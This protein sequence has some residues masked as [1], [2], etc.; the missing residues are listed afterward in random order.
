MNYSYLIPGSQSQPEIFAANTTGQ[1]GAYDKPVNAK[2]QLEV[3][4]SLLPSPPTIASYS[5]ETT[6][7]G[8]PQLRVSAPEVDILSLFEHR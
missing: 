8:E 2:V 1:L 4:Y 5:F 7:G 3:D 6:P